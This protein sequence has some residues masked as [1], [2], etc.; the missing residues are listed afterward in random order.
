MIKFRIN[1][2]AAKKK[3]STLEWFLSQFTSLKVDFHFFFHKVF[4]TLYIFFLSQ[5]FTNFDR[6]FFF[7]VFMIH[8]IWYNLDS[9][10]LRTFSCNFFLMILNVT[11]DKIFFCFM[12]NIIDHNI[13]FWQSQHF[14]LR[15][16][17]RLTRGAFNLK[18]PKKVI[19]SWFKPYKT[20][21]VLIYSVILFI[22]LFCNLGAEI[23][24]AQFTLPNIIL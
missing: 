2:S 18:V 17:F 16:C 12:Y 10:M 11:L 21:N 13:K 15:L 9:C 20:I 5:S 14:L 24:Q 1:C 3:W 6:F 4:L 23:E 19:T 22:S 7:T 8:M